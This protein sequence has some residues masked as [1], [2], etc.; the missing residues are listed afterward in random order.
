MASMKNAGSINQYQEFSRINITQKYIKDK[1]YDKSYIY[2]V[3]S[4]KYDIALSAK[5]NEILSRIQIQD[6]ID[7]FFTSKLHPCTIF[8][9]FTT[10]LFPPTHPTQIGNLSKKFEYASA[11]LSSQ[12]SAPH[13]LHYS[14][15]VLLLM[16]T[17]AYIWAVQYLTF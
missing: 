13:I 3:D 4:C 9:Y 16:I 7:T 11:F 6:I 15:R 5:S 8:F 14:D 12:V 2:F 10:I 1:V 17:F